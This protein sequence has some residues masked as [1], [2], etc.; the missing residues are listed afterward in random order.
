MVVKKSK[1]RNLAIAGIIAGSTSLGGC[2]TDSDSDSK[3]EDTN[4]MNQAALTTEADFKAD[5]E[6]KGGM[7]ESIASCNGHATCA[8]QSFFNGEVKVH[9][10]A[11]KNDCAGLNCKISS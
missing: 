6:A 11:G 5:C 1:L 7:L 4:N 9:D 8:G 3:T 2:F 10:C